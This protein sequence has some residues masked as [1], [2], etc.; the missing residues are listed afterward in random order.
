MLEDK[1][2]SFVVTLNQQAEDNL[3][4]DEIIITDLNE[5]QE[6][7]L[8]LAKE[9]P[10]RT[11]ELANIFTDINERTIR[12]DLNDMVDSGIL[13]AQGKTSD[14]YYILKE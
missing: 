11:G 2:H 6:K 14:R 4:I 7:I 3:S 9:G 5:R 10:I 12:R 1:G 13:E 8:E